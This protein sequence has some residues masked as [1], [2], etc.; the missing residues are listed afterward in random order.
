MTAPR[1]L[2]AGLL[3]TLATPATWP[4]ALAGFLLRGGIV[5]MAVPI[6]VLPT[7]VGVG[8]VVAPAL[9]SVAFGSVPVEFVAA[10]A[11][12]AIGS[13]AWLLLGGWLAAAAEAEG[14]RI[15]LASDD[16]REHHVDGVTAAEGPD[17][18]SVAGG[19]PGDGG[20]RV[21]TRILAAR[22]IASLPLA[23]ALVVGSIRLVFVTY[24]ELSNPGDVN[25]PIVARVLLGAPEVLVGVL[26]SWIFA[27]VLGAMAARRI[28]LSG[29]RV[30]EAL[31]DAVRISVRHPLATIVRFSVP[32]V[33]LTLVVAACAVAAAAA[34]ESVGSVLDGQVDAVGAALAVAL[35]VA[36]WV[37]GLISVA[38]VSAWRSA[39]WTLAAPTEARTFGGSGHRRPGDW[40]AD[41]SSATL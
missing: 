16:A 5:V 2:T 13:V 21:A 26:L 27:E 17:G 25:A 41:R 1:T 10:V 29:A 35:F 8:N 34:F 7:P 14:A 18:V 33:I 4:L 39:V 3:V 20:S 38:V 19:P 32:A 28:A 30:G 11:A 9:S 6:L 37:V 36:V 23:I 12:A 24:R 31:R 15:V 40:R 22:L